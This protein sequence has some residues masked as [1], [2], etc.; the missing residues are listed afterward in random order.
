MAKISG[1]GRLFH[2]LVAVL[3]GVLLLM[4]LAWL[5]AYRVKDNTDLKNNIYPARVQGI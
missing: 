1:Q 4:V 5:L 3:Y 2:D